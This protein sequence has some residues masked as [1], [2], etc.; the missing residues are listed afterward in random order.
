MSYTKG[1][2][3]NAALEEIGLASYEFDI[4]SESSESAL[5][6]L[7]SMMMEW[8]DRKSVV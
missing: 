7:D 2:L 3:V 8:K 6:R 5:R 1:E 4:S